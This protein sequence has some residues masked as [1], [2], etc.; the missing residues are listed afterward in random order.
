MESST[1][2][3]LASFAR[4]SHLGATHTPPKKQPV[5]TRKPSLVHVSY[6]GTFQPPSIASGLSGPCRIRSLRIP[7]LI[8]SVPL[9]PQLTTPLIPRLWTRPSTPRRFGLI[10]LGENASRDLFQ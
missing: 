10:R 7:H 4:W 6:I 3:T 5:R 2:R 8:G 9:I 1:K